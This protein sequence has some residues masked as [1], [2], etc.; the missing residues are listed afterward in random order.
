MCSYAVGLVTRIAVRRYGKAV[1]P[2]PP[3]EVGSVALKLPP[4]APPPRRRPRLRRSWGI[5]LLLRGRRVT[6][7]ETRKNWARLGV[8]A[9]VSQTAFMPTAILRILGTLV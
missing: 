7:L 2:W 8:R 1:W 5:G 4:P 3:F 6:D 9:A